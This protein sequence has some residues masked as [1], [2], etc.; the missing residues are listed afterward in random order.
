MAKE[1]Q[2]ALVNRIFDWELSIAASNHLRGRLIDLVCGGKPHR[3]LLPPRVTEHVGVDHEGPSY[4]R[5]N[6]D[7]LGTAYAIPVTDGSFNSALR[8]A[9]LEHLEGPEDE[10]PRCS[11]VLATGGIAVYM[12]LF[13]RHLYEDPRDINGFSNHIQ[14][15]LFEKAGFEM[16]ELKVLSGLWVTIGQLLA[17]NPYRANRDSLR[18]LRTVDAEGLLIW[19]L[20]YAMERMYRIELWPRIFLVVAKK[21]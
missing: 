9:V 15:Y 18:W 10:L 13:I 14:G 3:S 2:N 20:A 5:S 11:R 17:Y 16:V 1:P 8:T 21:R 7:L 6:F 19:G 12:L 4:D